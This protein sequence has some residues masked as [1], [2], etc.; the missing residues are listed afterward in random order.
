MYDDPQ[1]FP[2]DLIVKRTVAYIRLKEDNHALAQVG[3]QFLAETEDASTVSDLFLEVGKAYEHIRKFEVAI[4]YFNNGALFL[5]QVAF[6]FFFF[7][8]FT[9]A[10]SVRCQDDS[11]IHEVY[12]HLAICNLGK[13][14]LSEAQM[15][16]NQV[17]EAG[18]ASAPSLKGLILTYE[19][20]KSVIT[21]QTKSDVLNV[22]RRYQESENYKRK[23]RQNKADM[24][25]GEFDVALDSLDVKPKLKVRKTINKLK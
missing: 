11:N 5:D 1:Q 19:R 13:N 17:I 12:I 24:A 15:Y 4:A 22:A 6:F 21:A 3:L 9:A 16:Y 2:L 14:N 25:F 20:T 8:G 23:P 10:H 7:F 18:M